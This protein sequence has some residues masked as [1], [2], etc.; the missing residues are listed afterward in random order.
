MLPELLRPALAERIQKATAAGT[1]AATAPAPA[2]VAAP[3]AGSRRSSGGSALQAAASVS[4]PVPTAAPAAVPPPD[5]TSTPRK[6]ASPTSPSAAAATGTS[7]IEGMAAADIADTTATTAGVPPSEHAA[8]AASASGGGGDATDGAEVFEL[9]P[10]VAKRL[11]DILRASEEA[12]AADA[13]TLAA[14]ARETGSHSSYLP[15]AVAASAVPPHALPVATLAA[16]AAARQAAL[17]RATAIRCGA[18]WHEATQVLPTGVCASLAWTTGCLGDTLR[19][20][21]AGS[22]ALISPVTLTDAARLLAATAAA[23]SASAAPGAPPPRQS[24]RASKGSRDG[25]EGALTPAQAAVLADWDRARAVLAAETHCAAS[26]R[27]AGCA[28]IERARA[29]HA[30]E[31]LLGW[32]VAVEAKNTPTASAA[33]GGADVDAAEGRAARALGTPLGEAAGALG[34]HVELTALHAEN[35]ARVLAPGGPP[36]R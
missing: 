22:A 26:T 17:L 11:V 20:K 33:E 4:P 29:V 36:G 5:P 25:G 6:A 14:V 28:D 15:P 21:L 9:D 35:H 7:A 32:A 12:A 34:I 2:A 24:T 19:E 1:R 10:V 27:L 18:A 30:F 16:S 23:A 8:P 13:Q 3:A 31:G